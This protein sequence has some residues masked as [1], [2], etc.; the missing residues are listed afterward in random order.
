MS[1]IVLVGAN[2]KMSKTLQSCLEAKNKSFRIYTKENGKDASTK[3]FEGAEGII[4]FSLPLATSDVCRLAVSAKIPLVCGTTGWPSAEEA[5]KVFVSAAK[6]IPVVWDSNFSL[7]IE[8]LCEASEL[9]AKTITNGAAITDIH[10]SQKRDAPSGTALKIADRLKSVRQMPVEIQSIRIGEIFGE[11]RV[12]FSFEDET[13]ELT[14]KA[15]SRKPFALG[16]LRALEWARS[17]P[18]GLYSMKDVLK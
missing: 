12:L 9:L 16:A 7:G 8:L 3:N 4:D 1:F 18:P 11:H 15:S 2:G 10:H 14:H 13:I 5:K 6:T 17:Q